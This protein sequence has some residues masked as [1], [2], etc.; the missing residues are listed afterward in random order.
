VSAFGAA[1]MHY[2]QTLMLDPGNKIASDGVGF[3]DGRDINDAQRSAYFVS[4]SDDQPPK[5]KTP[6]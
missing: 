5:R 1:R 2:E 6:A 3:I 4:W